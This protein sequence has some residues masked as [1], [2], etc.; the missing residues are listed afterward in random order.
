MQ[1]NNVLEG[2]KKQD[3]TIRCQVVEDLG[4]FGNERNK[5]FQIRFW[6]LK[7]ILSDF[8]SGCPNLPE[9]I[10]L[11]KEALQAAYELE[12]PFLITVSN[13]HLAHRY[14]NMNE[15]ALAVTH[16]KIAIEG[17]EKL[18]LQH[19]YHA[20]FDRYAYAELLY[21]TRQYPS[22]I[23]YFNL[24][25]ELNADKKITRED[26]I[27]ETTLM[28]LY[29]TLGLACVKAKDPAAALASFTKAHDIAVNLEY[30][31]WISLTN[32]NIGDIYY[33]QGQYDT[34]KVLLLQDVEQ[35]L[36]GGKAWM[37]N[38]ANSLTKLANIHLLEKNTGLA[39]KELRQAET[40]LHGGT[41]P[42]IKADI[43]AAYMELYRYTG[44]ADSLFH[45]LA[46]YLE[47]HDVV[48]RKAANEQAEIIQVQLNN[49]ENIY[50][51]LTLNKEKKR[52]ALIRNFLIIAVIL[53]AMF[54]L[55]YINRQR[56]KLLVS[57]K[58]ALAEKV[59]AEA[60]AQEA[61]HQLNVFT[62]HMMD[63]TGLVET[64][65][66]QLLQKEKDELQISH[67]RELSQH[68]ILTDADWSRFKTL[69]EQV[70]PGFFKQLK[71]VSPDITLAEQRV[72]ALTKLRITPKHAANLL[73]ITHASVNR[74]RQR[75][76]QRLGLDP[77]ADIDIYFSSYPS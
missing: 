31:E 45:Y 43:Y 49:Q 3:S 64:L 67:I 54:G 22:S 4:Q 44:N 28:F 20:A 75:L 37:E 58:Q 53:C 16:M 26:S 13:K 42:S 57:N 39:L 9:S 76:R 68:P 60:E 27:N 35:S 34:A 1:F 24:A 19:F 2:I 10:S 55:L 73:G 66:L 8:Q 47:H 40:L 41:Y 50:H 48:E 72:A 36:S 52:I 7:A 6:L 46:L 77:E 15:F 69:F 5:R 14:R 21:L 59:N 12:D 62:Q 11:Y 30:P 61:I 23:D 71:S 25:L 29:N 38:A 56:L 63:K 74:T 51:I 17:Q 18:G 33:D 70:Y 65:Q 32:G